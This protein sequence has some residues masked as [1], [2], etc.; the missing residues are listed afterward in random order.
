MLG[1]N[2][3]AISVSV[4][5]YTFYSPCMD[6]P[7]LLSSQFCPYRRLKLILMSM[8]GILF[9]LLKGFNIKGLQKGNKEFPDTTGSSSEKQ[10]KA[11]YVRHKKNPSYTRH[12]LSLFLFQTYTK[13]VLVLIQSNSC[14]FL[15]HH[16]FRLTLVMFL[17]RS[18]SRSPVVY[19]FVFKEVLC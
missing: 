10:K 8:V 4:C 18:L 5:L 6:K 14:Y 13:S 19:S 2:K 3:S 12:N 11:N 1:R 15:I 7:Y 16:L 17:L 9:A